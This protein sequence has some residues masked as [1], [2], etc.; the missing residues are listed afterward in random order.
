M[1]YLDFQ[2]HINKNFRNDAI[3]KS[4]YSENREWILDFLI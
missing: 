4:L 3:L 1:K 2:T